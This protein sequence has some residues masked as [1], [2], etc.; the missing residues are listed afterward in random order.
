MFWI[1]GERLLE[2]KNSACKNVHPI[3]KQSNFGSTYIGSNFFLHP[4]N[5]DRNANGRTVN[6][7]ETYIATFF[8]SLWI[9]K[10]FIPCPIVK[11]KTKKE[12]TH[13]YRPSYIF[14]SFF[15]LTCFTGCNLIKLHDI[16]MAI[17]FPLIL[18][19]P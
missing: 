10:Y 5:T 4:E 1:F 7:A 11:L 12:N 9:Q 19:L 16:R 3:T 15:F 8:F 6:I 2:C 14:I 17:F 13:K 18:K